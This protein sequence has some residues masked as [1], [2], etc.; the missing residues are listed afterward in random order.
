[1]N[2]AKKHRAKGF[3]LVELIIVIT[4][5]AVVMGAVYSLYQTQQRS[6][7]SQDEIVEV[8]QNLRIALD[9]IARDVRMAGALVPSSVNPFSSY[10]S[11][12]INNVNT[13][14]IRLN[15]ASA[16]GVFAWIDADSTTPVTPATELAFR[17]DSSEAANFFTA[18]A[19]TGDLVRIL[20]RRADE[21]TDDLFSRS[22]RVKAAND[23]TAT[24]VPPNLVL[25]C[26][27]GNFTG[28]IQVSRGD[29]I[30][31]TQSEG[32]EAYPNSI[33]YRVV[34]GA[35]GTACQAGQTCLARNVNDTTNVIIAQNIKD[36]QLRFILTNNTEVDPSNPIA[37]TNIRAV[38]VIVEGE[39]KTSA[40]LSGGAKTRRLESI[41]KLRNGRSS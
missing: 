14:R 18:N 24:P 29:V 32:V 25:K 41:V 35:E 1:M 3:T 9:T 13:D 20:R 5:F 15:T 34:N 19:T 21:Q 27:A 23:N 6:A 28:N 39:T 22:F 7:Y 17:I 12:S 16:D 40:L 26:D 30:V 10:S 31:K 11:V 2:L 8:Q 37:L 38:R 4:V 36:L 33:V